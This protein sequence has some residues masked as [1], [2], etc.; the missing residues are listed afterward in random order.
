MKSLE[1]FLQQPFVAEPDFTL[2]KYLGLPS[3]FQA[4][5]MLQSQAKDFSALPLVAQSQDTLQQWVAQDCTYPGSLISRCVFLI[6]STCRIHSGALWVA[7]FI[8]PFLQ[9]LSFL[10]SII[11]HPM[12]YIIW[13]LGGASA[14]PQP[15]EMLG[16]HSAVSKSSHFQ[17][18]LP[19]T[20]CWVSHSFILCCILI[21]FSLYPT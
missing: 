17:E 15:Y 2:P 6:T 5:G 19:I 3:L 12:P 8:I 7:G 11:S 20:Q 13:T 9:L 16:M 21:T 4:A 10:F 18:V 14:F 1:L